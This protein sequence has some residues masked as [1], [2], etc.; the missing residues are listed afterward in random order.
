[1][2]LE[3][4]LSHQKIWEMYLYFVNASGA[5]ALVALP[6]KSPSLTTHKHTAQIQNSQCRFTCASFSLSRKLLTRVDTC[7]YKIDGFMKTK[8]KS[9]GKKY[10]LLSCDNDTAHIGNVAS[11]NSIV[12]HVFM[13][14]VM[15]LSSR[16]LVTIWWYTHR[17]MGWIYTYQV[18]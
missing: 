14:A 16:C 9:S 11:N 15:L 18:S 8:T 10:S 13:V 6:P 5:T 3:R 2:I 1:M 4:Q 12:V 7:K 17:L